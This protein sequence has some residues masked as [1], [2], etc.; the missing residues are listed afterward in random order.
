MSKAAFLCNYTS[1]FIVTEIKDKLDKNNFE[2]EFYIPG[3]NQ[4][5]QEIIDNNSGLYKFEPDVIFIS[6]DLSTY[7]GEILNELFEKSSTEIYFEIE[8][9]VQNILELI[10]VTRVC[11]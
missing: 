6:I 8:Q 5:A 3:F 11:L 2:Y 1:D 4:Y 7:I 10:C 9:Q